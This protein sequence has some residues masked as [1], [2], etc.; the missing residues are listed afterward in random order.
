MVKVRERCATKRKDA[1][2]MSKRIAQNAKMPSCQRFAHLVDDGQ[3]MLLQR[4]VLMIVKF[5]RSVSVAPPGMRTQHFQSIVSQQ[6][7]MGRQQSREDGGKFKKMQKEES[8]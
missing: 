5:C 1:L 8:I 7:D 2:S 3:L 4:S 6:M